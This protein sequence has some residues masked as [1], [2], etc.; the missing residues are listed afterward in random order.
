MFFHEGGDWTVKRL[1]QMLGDVEQV[2]ESS[3]YGKFSASLG[4]SFSATVV[5]I[6]V[7]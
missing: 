1:L 6:N 5:G 7:S 3:G 4:V 2:Y